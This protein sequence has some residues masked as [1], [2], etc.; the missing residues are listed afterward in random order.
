MLKDFLYIIKLI[1]ATI[2]LLN[3]KIFKNNKLIIFNSKI[4]YLKKCLK[5]FNLFIK[6]TTKLQAENYPTIYYLCY[7]IHKA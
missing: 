7:D 1:N 5:I 2:S 4:E 6:T 3:I